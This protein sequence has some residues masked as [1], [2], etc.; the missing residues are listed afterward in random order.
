MWGEYCE[1]VLC[2]C[3]S[4]LVWRWREYFGICPFGGGGC[5]CPCG[6]AGLCQC[7]VL[8]VLEMESVG[9][10]LWVF[11]VFVDAAAAYVCLGRFGVDV[12]F[13]VLICVVV[14]S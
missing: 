10:F 9:V 11:G 12:C 4:C 8:G 6:S 5:S 3:D 13:D 7:G 1:S 2:W 14:V